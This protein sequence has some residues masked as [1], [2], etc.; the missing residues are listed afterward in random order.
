MC[1]LVPEQ[2]ESLCSGKINKGENGYLKDS[3]SLCPHFMYATSF[4]YLQTF[5]QVRVC[6][7]VCVYFFTDNKRHEKMLL[8]LANCVISHIAILQNI[9]KLSMLAELKK[10][11]ALF[12]IVIPSLGFLKSYFQIFSNPNMNTILIYDINI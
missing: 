2:T 3:K 5:I 8:F 12:Y 1:A 11:L 10:C 4:D 6:V 9:L 7:C